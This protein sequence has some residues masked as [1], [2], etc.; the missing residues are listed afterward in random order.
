M[1]DLTPEERMAVL[2]TEMGHLKEDVAFVKLQVSNHLPHQIGAVQE[3]VDKLARKMGD[4]DAVSKFLSV[5]IK[6]LAIVVTIIWSTIQI[7]KS[8]LGLGR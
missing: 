1:A 2:E 7:V 3:S 4:V 6:G 8:L 5:V